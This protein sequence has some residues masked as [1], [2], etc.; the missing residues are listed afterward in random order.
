VG[1][2]IVRGYEKSAGPPDR[3]LN[4]YFD[5]MKHG[6]NQLVYLQAK[7]VKVIQR[8]EVISRALPSPA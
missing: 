2:L 3:L 5:L 4:L 6:H 7:F 8:E 1:G